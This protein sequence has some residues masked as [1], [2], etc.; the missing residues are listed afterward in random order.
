MHRALAFLLIA[1]SLAA[2]AL[3]GCGSSPARRDDTLASVDVPASGSTSSGGA[4]VVAAA[5]IGPP[6]SLSLT[7]PET[8]ILGVRGENVMVRM[9][10]M[11]TNPNPYP[12]TMT[13]LDGILYLDGVNAATARVE[14]G[15]VLQARETRVYQLDASVPI[16]MVV[17]VRSRMYTTSG[18]ITAT[19]PNGN[20]FVS[21]FSFNGPIPGF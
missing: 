15:D 12:V 8:E 14:G 20:G 9:R 16:Q 19:D 7:R 1:S 3:V 10:V 17:G 11:I 5:P 13:V 18:T 21:P 4:T 2:T 6:E